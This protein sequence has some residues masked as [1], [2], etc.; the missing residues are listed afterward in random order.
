MPQNNDQL[1]WRVV[2]W[3]G[4]TRLSKATLYNLIDEGKVQ[5]IKVGKSRLITT[6]PAAFLKMVVEEET[7]PVVDIS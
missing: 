1:A 5:S 7:P 3:C 4:C 2:E 6:S